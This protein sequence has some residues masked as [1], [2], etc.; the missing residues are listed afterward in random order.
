LPRWSSGTGSGTAQGEPQHAAPP[1]GRRDVLRQP[2]NQPP[3][4]RQHHRRIQPASPPNNSGAFLPAGTAMANNSDN[5]PLDGLPASSFVT[6][7]KPCPLSPSTFQNRP[8]PSQSSSPCP[9]SSHL[10]QQHPWQQSPRHIKPL[11]TGS[12]R[13][14][15]KS[16]LLKVCAKPFGR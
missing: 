2:V 6:I 8:K 1:F 9:A 4:Q 12:P 16:K 3:C 11:A 10:I 5:A 14:R 7:C 15:P 13:P